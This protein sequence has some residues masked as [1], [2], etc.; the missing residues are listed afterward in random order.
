MTN[1]SKFSTAGETLSPPGASTLD[2]PS[3]ARMLKM[4]L[5]T[6]LP[7]AMSRSPLTLAMTEV[8][9]SGSDVPAATTVRPTTNSL[10][11]RCRAIVTA[12]ST[13]QLEPCTSRSRPTM[14]SAS[15]TLQWRSHAL[16]GI[17]PVSA[18]RADAA[19]LTAARLWRMRKTVYPVSMTRNSAPSPRLTVPSRPSTNSSS[20]NPIM[21]GTS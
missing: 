4:L 17:S 6:I 7:M 8:A 2:T 1:M 13:S 5:P 16:L 12:A 11:P 18:G 10:T 20:D 19:A 15:C 9:T 21:I 3:T 14:M